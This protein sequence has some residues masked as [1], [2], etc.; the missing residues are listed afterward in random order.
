MW[1]SFN[2]KKSRKLLNLSR[3]ECRLAV[4][5][6][7]GHSLIGHHAWRMGLIQNDT[8]PDLARA[9]LRVLG[10]ISFRNLTEVSRCDMRKLIDFARESGVFDLY[11]SRP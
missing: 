8:C 9:R 6:Y 5:I 1:G 10:W 4:G 3:S 7:T 11:D 2:F